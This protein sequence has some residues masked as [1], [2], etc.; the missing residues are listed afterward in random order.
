MCAFFVRLAIVHVLALLALRATSE[1][2]IFVYPSNP[3]WLKALFMR[4]DRCGMQGLLL[5]IP[6]QGK[7]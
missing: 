4:V 1:L 6:A 2:C 7:R 3:P 5:R